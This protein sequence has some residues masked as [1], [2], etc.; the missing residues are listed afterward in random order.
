MLIG[1]VFGLVVKILI[2]YIRVLEFESCLHSQFQLPSSTNPGRQE[3]MIQITGI[4]PFTWKP[5][6]KFLAPSFDLAQTQML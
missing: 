3:K 5:W 6:I 4:L 2:S 1:W